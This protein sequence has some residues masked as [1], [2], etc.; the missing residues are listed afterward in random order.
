MRVVPQQFL[1]AM[2]VAAARAKGVR[3]DERIARSQL[4]RIAAT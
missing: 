3:V 4:Q 2:T 1:T